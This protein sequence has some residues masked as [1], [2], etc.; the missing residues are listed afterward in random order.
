MIITFNAIY[1]LLTLLKLTESQE[2]TT[3]YAYWFL[4]K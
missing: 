4:Y 3:I 2:M 1:A